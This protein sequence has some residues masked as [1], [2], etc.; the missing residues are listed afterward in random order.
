MY[1]E[2]KDSWILK[3]NKT[4]FD[5]NNEFIEDIN[6]EL[7]S[8]II[9]SG[10]DFI[11]D[12]YDK[13][14]FGG[15]KGVRTHLQNI[16]KE[17]KDNKLIVKPKIHKSGYGRAYYNKCISLGHIPACVRH[18][19]A[20][21]KYMDFDL[22]N[23][24][25]NILYQICIKNGVNENK[26]K[27]IK[28]YC[29]KREDTIEKVVHHYF[30]IDTSHKDYKEKRKSVKTLF[31]RMGLYLGGFNTWR[32]ENGL[33]VNVEPLPFLSC[34]KSECIYIINNYVKPNNQDVYREIC[35]DIKKQKEKNKSYC[36]DPNSTL[37]SYF[38]C[39][40]ERKIIE[41][42][43]K[44]LMSDYDIEDYHFIYCYD[45]F[46]LSIDIINKILNENNEINP[47]CILKLLEQYTENVG[48]N[49]KWTIKEFDEDI[50]EEVERLEKGKL[51]PTYYIEGDVLNKGESIV[52][53][54]ILKYIRPICK[55]SQKHFFV[56]NK[57]NGLWEHHE[58]LYHL[59]TDTIN[60]C[61]DGAIN[62]TTKSV[63]K[64]HN[65]ENKKNA[66]KSISGL[67]S[68]YSKI[69]KTGY[70]NGIEKDYKTLLH[71]KTFYSRLDSEIDIIAFKNGIYNL[72]TKQL[73]PFEP[74]DFITKK[75]DYDY[76]EAEQEDIDFVMREVLKICNVNK[77]HRDYY[78]SC[79][80]QT[81][82]GRPLKVLYYL[83]GL[84]GDNGKSMLLDTIENIFPIY[85]SKIESEVIEKGCRDS[86]K[87]IAE[88]RGS[89]LVYIE[90][91]DKKRLN[92]KM[93]KNLSG[94]DKINYKVMYGTSTDLLIRFN[95]FMISN[96]T[97]NLKSDG[98]TKNRNR[99]ITFESQFPIEAE[100]DDYDNKVF[101]QD[102]EL[103]KKLRTT[104]RNAFINIMIDYANQYYKEGGTK[105]IPQ[106]F[107]D[108]TENLNVV[109]EDKMDEWIKENLILYE[110]TK[111]SKTS[112]TRAYKNF[113]GYKSVNQRDFVDKIKLIF[114]IK[115]D[116]DLSCGSDSD[117][118]RIKG[119]WRG[120]NL[121]ND[122]D[123]YG[124]YMVNNGSCHLSI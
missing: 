28:Q 17:I 68:F 53:N 117:N 97:P 65:E 49:I 118:K 20:K 78:L 112:L 73:K 59:I 107:K 44:D 48:Y 72:K 114:N 86:H 36:K 98:G 41:S 76:E 33:D 99:M 10:Y 3:N 64:I 12:R 37:M 74:S 90:E 121:K 111:L 21:G 80:G 30:N 16:L 62:Q 94:G 11:Y 66:R 18:T 24:H 120:I 69:C 104:Y 43:L 93:L 96:H 91:L 106:E 84:T 92:E 2:K 101:K 67:A 47:N 27:S 119:G 29:E 87:S 42:V 110:N 105:P 79:L 35:D 39:N 70:V 103:R 109:N 60:K 32:T 115:Y 5:G 25:F 122:D 9:D 82:T 77:K 124:N 7:L 89:R 1:N 83:V 38:L 6:T 8:R 15:H 56:Y 4:I 26:I 54:Y 108:D 14:D 63:E 57:K 51:T 75:L 50:M 116:K 71:D 55:Y 22:E 19:L 58:N 123:V 95:M 52:G 102:K 45:G 88:L 85:V 100:E 81:L 61:I 23:A 113:T 34:I 31:I 40:E 46:L 13:F